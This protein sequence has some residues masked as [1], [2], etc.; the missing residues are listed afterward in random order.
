MG[1]HGALSVPWTTHL[2]HPG[3][4]LIDVVGYTTFY[5]YELGLELWEIREIL[6]MGYLLCWV[7]IMWIGIMGS[8]LWLNGL[9][10]EVKIDFKVSRVVW[11]L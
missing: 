7:N 1:R 11:C 8:V 3:S 9:E 5:R 10:L 2:G 6:V 4:L